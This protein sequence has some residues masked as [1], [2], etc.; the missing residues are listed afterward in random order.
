[1]EQRASS[2]K[3]KADRYTVSI[4]LERN[5]LNERLPSPP[6]FCELEV[7]AAQARMSCMSEY[8]LLKLLP[9]AADDLESAGFW[10]ERVPQFENE[11][12]EEPSSFFAEIGVIL[13]VAAN[14]A[15]AVTISLAL[16]HV[17]QALAR[18]AQR[19]QP[20]GVAHIKLEARGPQ[21]KA[22]FEVENPDDQ[23]IDHIV[24]IVAALS[25]PAPKISPAPARPVD[26]LQ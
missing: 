24:A 14:A 12:A 9:E 2:P 20:D 25:R 3:S 8:V 6:G 10:F 17:A 11:L 4:G 1:V 13:S 5:K 22:T 15:D 19:N 23:A 21:G 16:R 26:D 7:W 18:I